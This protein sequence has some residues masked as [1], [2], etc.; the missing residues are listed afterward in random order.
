M[1]ELSDGLI[2][3]LKIARSL[4]LGLG[5]KLLDGLGTEVEGIGTDLAFLL[6]ARDD[7]G[8]L[9][10]DLLGKTTK[11]GVAATRSKAQVAKSLRGNLALDTVVG[12]GNTL[13]NLQPLESL[14][15]ASG[16]VRKHATNGAPE[17]LARRAKMEWTVCGVCVGAEVKEAQIT[18]CSLSIC[19]CKQEC[20]CGVCLRL[21]R[22]RLPVTL[23]SSQRTTTTR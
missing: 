23:S 3:T 4:G 16:L 22:M 7:L 10:A 17:H 18:L 6:E 8:V 19:E 13:E 14:S 5:T 20:K 9:P 12:R 1:A 15:T 2:D 21:L 11:D